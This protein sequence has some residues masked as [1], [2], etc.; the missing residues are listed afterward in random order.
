M[1]GRLPIVVTPWP[2]VGLL[3]FPA[4]N[5]AAAPLG[6]VSFGVLK[7]VPQA[8]AGMFQ[9]L[10]LFQSAWVFRSRLEI[11]KAVKV[12]PATP[13]PPWVSVWPSAV[14][15]AFCEPASCL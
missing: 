13:A 15:S 12:T 9:F 6:S 14:P 7:S 3:T 1:T 8:S 2:F 5:A 11:G 10:R 4:S